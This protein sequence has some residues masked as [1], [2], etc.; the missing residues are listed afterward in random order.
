MDDK[1]LIKKVTIDNFRIMSVN[2]ELN[3][4]AYV[5]IQFLKGEK[6]IE[7]GV[8]ILDEEEYL[9]WGSDDNYIISKVCEKLD[10][11]RIQ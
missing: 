9:E 10:F 5:N 2:V 1:E 7:N 3:K 11:K 6:P 8:I 4:K